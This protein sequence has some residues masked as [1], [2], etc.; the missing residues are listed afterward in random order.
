MNRLEERYRRVLRLLPASYR[1]V[2]EEDMVATFLASVATDD[3]EEAEYLADFGRPSWPEVFSIVALAIRLRIGSAGAPPRYAAWSEAIRLSV[4]TG[5]LVNAATSTVDA[6]ITLWQAGMIPLLP[7]PVMLEPPGYPDAWHRVHLFA[8][9]AGLLW[10]PAFV[11]L[12]SGRW[13]ATRWLGSAAATTAGSAVVTVVVTGQRMPGEVWYTIIINVL[14]VLALAALHP[15]APKVDRRS[16]LGALGVGTLLFAAYAW[17]LS[18]PS[19]PL[20]PLDWAGLECVVVV[21]VVAVHLAGRALRWWG[22][23]PVW[24]LTLAIIAFAVLG[25]RL[26]AL[27][28]YARFGTA[29][30][31]PATVGLGIAEAAAVG[32]AAIVLAL[33][34]ARALRR[35][36]AAAAD[37]DAWSTTPSPP[38]R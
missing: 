17:L 3:R 22:R 4:L 28:D 15:G 7:A 12:V 13:A 18:R 8:V 37:A 16:W 24:T 14:L 1:G 5:M 19:A 10:L 27:T 11:A 30:W 26:V 35:L 20:P 33:L 2:W 9:L 21:A 6:V 29:G 25:Q 38:T 23:F 36:S 31:H 34:S 32:A